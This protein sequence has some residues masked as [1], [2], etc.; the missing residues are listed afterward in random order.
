MGIGAGTDNINSVAEL[1]GN[2][3]I[4]RDSD[5]DIIHKNS[6]RPYLPA[7]IIFSRSAL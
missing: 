6:L 5:Y 3:F 1:S 2:G 7:L 4:L